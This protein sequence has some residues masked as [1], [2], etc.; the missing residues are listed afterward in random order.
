MVA[1]V[2]SFGLNGYLGLGPVRQD[3]VRK[4]QMNDTIGVDISKDTLD[5]YW[6]SKREHR[7]FSN[8]NTGLKSLISWVQRAKVSLI[9]FESTGIYHRLLET[10]LAK[11]CISFAR[12]NPRQARRFCEG[13]GQLAKTDRG[14]SRPFSVVMRTTCQAVD[15][16]IACL[17]ID[18]AMLA[19]MGSLLELKADQ[20][21]SET[22]HDLKQLATAR[23]ALLKDRTAARARLHTATHS[24]LKRQF[25]LRLRQIERDLAQICAAMEA[26]VSADRDLATRANILTSIPGIGRVTALALLIDPLMIC[27]A[28]HCRAAHARTGKHER[29]AGRK[30][31]WSRTNLTPIRFSVMQASPASQWASGRARNAS[32]AGGPVCGGRSTCQRS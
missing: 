17:V 16:N 4:R 5:A 31:G 28:N 8:D 25:G 2:F 23:Q 13:A 20:P 32:K 30:S 26:T 9:V 1:L 21:R 18:A 24:L 11:H 29:K 10:G 27:P 19:R 3:K 6:L 14:P 12:V 7:Q 22:L 15:G